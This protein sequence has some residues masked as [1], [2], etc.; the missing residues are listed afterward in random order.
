MRRGLSADTWMVL[1]ISAASVWFLAACWD[2]REEDAEPAETA[3]VVPLPDSAD[4]LGS[5]PDVQADAGGEPE[6]PACATDDD[7]AGGHTCVEGICREICSIEDP[8]TGELTLCDE[9]SGYCGVCSSD[10]DCGTSRACKLALCTEDGIDPRDPDAVT[11]M[12]AGAAPDS[13]GWVEDAS[14]CG[15]DETWCENDQLW[16][17]NTES[18]VELVQNC[19]A[20]GLVCRR[21]QAPVCDTFAICYDAGQE[22]PLP[23]G[24]IYIEV[25]VELVSGATTPDGRQVFG[26]VDLHYVDTTL[27]CWTESPADCHWRNKTPDWRVLGDTNDDPL[28]DIDDIDVP[29]PGNLLHA[30]PASGTYTIGVN[31][32]DDSGLGDALVTVRV[33]GSGELL[34]EAQ[35]VLTP[36]Q[37]WYVGDLAVPTLSF[38]FENLIYGNISQADCTPD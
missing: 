12:D 5:F 31:Y 30:Q 22:C 13:S 18:G 29:E 14:V 4:S 34:H 35:Q 9:V 25:D 6:L 17:C 33:Y 32:Y 38:T 36:Q 37:F 20:E 21:G 23:D 3:D 8:C 26:D 16:S 10:S 24:A 1:A 28:L 7:C 19:A 15:G 27:G 2:E 11:D